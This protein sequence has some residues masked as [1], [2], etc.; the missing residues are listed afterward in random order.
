[1]TLRPS[2]YLLIGRQQYRTPA[3]TEVRLGYATRLARLITLEPE[4]AAQLADGHV[5]GIPSAELDRLRDLLAVVDDSEDELGSV[6]GDFLAG[7]ADPGVRAFTIMP[8]SYCNMAC[9]YCG[10]EHFKSAVS[11][12]RVDRLATRVEATIADPA[13]SSV[14]V[15]WFGGEPLLALRVIRELS[16]RF[17][18][19]ADAAGKGYS[20]GMATN[21]SL[22]TKPALTMLHRDCKLSSVVITIDGPQE[23]HDKRRIKRNGIGSFHRTVAVIAD[24]VRERSLPELKIIIRVNVDSENEQAVSDLIIDLA[25]FGLTGPQ[26]SL[27]TMPVHSWGNDVSAVELDNRRYARLEAEWLRLAQALG[28]GFSNLPT[29]PRTRTCA[30][31]TTRRR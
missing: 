7:S 30:A 23:L 3:G 20:A 17:V 5:T 28:I 9:D 27:Q 15:T 4:V 26:I 2:R 10:Q 25:C 11:A 1:M 21:G 14:A 24:V 22:L 29:A 18:V 19:A 13:T 8:T 31:T 16:A 12:R 6:L